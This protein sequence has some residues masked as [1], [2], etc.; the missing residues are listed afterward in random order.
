MLIYMSSRV[1]NKKTKKSNKF[2]KYF[3]I[4]FGII[5][6]AL[7]GYAYYL[8]NSVKGT[9]I[10]M[11]ETVELDTPKPEVK[12]GEELITVLLMGVD[13]REGDKGRSDT[14]IVLTL[15]PKTDSMQMVSIPRDTY[16]TIVGK[17][18]KDK[19]NHAYA[20][21][22]TKM[23][24]ETVEEF[25]GVPINYFVKVNMEALSDLVD[26]VG[27]ITVNNPL[28]WYDDR[29][30]KKGYHYKKGEISLDGPQTLGYVRMRYQ[31]PRG[32]FGRTDR[33]RQVIKAIIDKGASVSSITRVN[34][35]LEAV[36]SNAKTNITFDEMKDL[37]A[38]YKDT[39]K[40]INSYMVQGKGTKINSGYYLVI[41]EAERDKVN[42]LLTDHLTTSK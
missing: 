22:G 9:A 24:V 36:G 29:Y 21:G 18:N 5:L 37:L 12:K 32:D 23:A 33:Q 1:E 30:Y 19:I 34:E 35:I 13:E 31:D 40:N 20:Y 39:R 2:L 10:N 41:S 7:G 6:L 25:T 15:N 8:Y 38:N 4:V 28:D 16:T 17:G 14:L 11:H 42:K 26:A 27:G 3:L